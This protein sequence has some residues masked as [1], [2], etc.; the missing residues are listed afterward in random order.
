MTPTA[1]NLDST[2]AD[3]VRDDQATA[4]TVR[5]GD[6][7]PTRTRHRHIRL[8]GRDHHLPRPGRHARYPSDQIHICSHF[9]RR[10]AELLTGWEERKM[11]S[12]TGGRRGIRRMLSP[13]MG[14]LL[15][16]VGVALLTAACSASA[17]PAGAR[18][19]PTSAPSTGSGT[20]TAPAGSSKYQKGVAYAQC[21]REH[22]VP[23]FPD[24]LPKGGFL[25]SPSITGGIGG[26]VSP[27]YQAAEN[28]CASLSPVGVLSPQQ[29]QH[30]LSQLLK[31]TACMRSHG[32]K[33]FPDPTFSSQGITLHIVGFDRGSPQ[34]QNAMNTCTKQI[35][36][37]GAVGSAG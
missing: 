9:T 3:R 6:R 27:Q 19:S 26:Q 15:A 8:T 31:V 34:F 12:H 1:A 35:G 24:P 33:N 30:M 5:P 21:M 2:A 20:S 37:S 4:G 29:Q 18:T 32:Y 23:N 14:L 16:A 36:A 25:L 28:S 22:G 10:V 7:W 11:N 17:N 13:R